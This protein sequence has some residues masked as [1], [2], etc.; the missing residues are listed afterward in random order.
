MK[1]INE[2][3]IRKI[4]LEKGNMY[5]AIDFDKTITSSE[6]EDSWGAAG[7]L[8]GDEFIEKLN[9]LYKKYGPIEFDY[10]ITFEEKNL[11]MEIW[12]QTCM[13]LYYEYRLTKEK[14]E[15]GVEKSNFILRKGVKEFLKEMNENKVPV[16]ILSAGIG[17]VIEKFLKD[18]NCYFENIIIIS[19]FIKFDTNGNM[20]KFQDKM[21][22]SLNKNIEGKLPDNWKKIIDSKKYKL[23]IGDTI[24]DKK[25]VPEK[26]WKNTISVG[27]LNSKIEENIEFYKKSFDIVLTD[28]EA[29]FDEVH[30]IL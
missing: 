24:E 2:E 8:L 28:K 21:I 22:H 27:F 17:N 18:N 19:N 3:K 12:Y 26:E 5:V 25:M 9:I 20:K 16:I 10:K 11:A 30:C 29:N 1:Y 15:E 4:K 14:M 7:L 23:L 13:D 6:S